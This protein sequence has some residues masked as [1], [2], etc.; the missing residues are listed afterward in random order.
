MVLIGRL[1][2]NIN[3]L[4]LFVLTNNGNEGTSS[5]LFYFVDQKLYFC[6]LGFTIFNLYIFHFH[7]RFC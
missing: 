3:M 5:R 2:L 6:R 1:L 7:L 4:L